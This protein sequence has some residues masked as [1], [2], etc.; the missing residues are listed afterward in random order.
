MYRMNQLSQAA[1][2]R[3]EKGH[4]YSPPPENVFASVVKDG[5]ENIEGDSGREIGSKE[6]NKHKTNRTSA[7]IKNAGRQGKTSTAEIHRKIPSAI[8]QRDQHKSEPEIHPSAKKKGLTGDLRLEPQKL[9]V[10]T[11][12]TEKATEVVETKDHDLPKS[13]VVKESN[14]IQDHPADVAPIAEPVE[15]PQDE[16]RENDEDEGE[17]E[18]GEQNKHQEKVE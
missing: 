5:N 2:E 12:P 3:R 4:V 7:L 1:E 17:N 15:E 11:A 10:Q 18:E 6:G 13:P 8:K 16:A 9:K 14:E